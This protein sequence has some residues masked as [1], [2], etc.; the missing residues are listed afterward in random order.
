MENGHKYSWFCV[1]SYYYSNDLYFNG[2][3]VPFLLGASRLLGDDYSINDFIKQVQ[4]APQPIELLFCSTEE[5]YVFRVCEKLNSSDSV[6]GSLIINDCS[7]QRYNIEEIE[8]LLY[9]KYNKLIKEDKFSN[10][11]GKWESFNQFE[12]DNI[13]K[14]SV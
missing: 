7:L 14:T 11:S 3:T 13:L 8:N 10:Y 1:L 4:L 12:I 5:E 2:L 6:F 9:D